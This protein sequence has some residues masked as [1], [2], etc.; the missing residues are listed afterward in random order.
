MDLFGP[1]SQEYC[2]Y[3]YFLSV[4]GYVLFILA[5]GVAIYQM[6]SKKKSVSYNQLF[7]V[8][9]GYFIMYFQNRLLYTMCIH[10]TTSKVREGLIGAI[11]APQPKP[12]Q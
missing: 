11:P 3:F 9:I 12:K 4:F 1:F 8:M 7:M 5:I 6:F 2:M 10:S